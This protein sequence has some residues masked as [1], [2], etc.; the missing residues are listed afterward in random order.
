M[1]SVYQAT[2]VAATAGVAERVR[3]EYAESLSGRFCSGTTPSPRTRYALQ[4]SK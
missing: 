3:A 4:G 1:R 2:L